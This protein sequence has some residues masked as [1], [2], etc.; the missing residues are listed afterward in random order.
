MGRGYPAESVA[1]IRRIVVAASLKQ[2][3]LGRFSCLYDVPVC[4][5]EI[6]GQI[7]DEH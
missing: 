2:L 7:Q 6:E 5:R 3:L 1:S 4:V